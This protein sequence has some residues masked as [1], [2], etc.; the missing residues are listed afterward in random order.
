[1]LKAALAHTQE[2]V[3]AMQGIF[4]HRAVDAAAGGL[5]A[6]GGESLHHAQHDLTAEHAAV[7]VPP[8]SEQPQWHQAGAPAEPP[9]GAPC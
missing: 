6:A 2:G 3:K 5:A 1:M 8:A 4:R 7:L 9:P